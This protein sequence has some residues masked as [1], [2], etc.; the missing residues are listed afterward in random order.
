MKLKSGQRKATHHQLQEA[1]RVDALLKSNDPKAQQLGKKLREHSAMAPYWSAA[2]ANAVFTYKLAARKRISI[3]TSVRNYRAVTLIPRS[4][5][6]PLDEFDVSH[7][8]K[9]ERRIRNAYLNAGIGQSNPAFLANDFEFDSTRSLVIIHFH[10][11]VHK[12]D[13]RRL[14]KL[15]GTKEFRRR[16]DCYNPIRISPKK[17]GQSIF[18][19]IDYMMKFRWFNR[20]TY[21]RTG[22]NRLH[23]GRPRQARPHLLVPFLVALADIHPSK[24]L[25]R[26]GGGKGRH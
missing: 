21:I 23:R 6:I 9:N 24:L 18:G 22:S 12:D 15:R 10:G 5:A 11:I 17:P 25:F 1:K 3:A 19:Y 20:P 4:G 26:V 13:L 8:Q 2:S 16:P 7:L 14:D